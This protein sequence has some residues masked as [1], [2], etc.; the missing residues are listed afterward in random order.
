MFGTHNGSFWQCEWRSIQTSPCNLE[1]ELEF[2]GLLSDPYLQGTMPPEVALL[3]KLEEI[4]IVESGLPGTIETVFPVELAES[5]TNLRLLSFEGN[6]L[7]GTLPTYLSSLTNLQYLKFME[8]AFSGTI[9]S[10]LG[11]LTELIELNLST[12]NIVGTVPTELAG[13][14]KLVS[15][16]ISNTNL[17][18]SIPA[19]VCNLPLLETITCSQMSCCQ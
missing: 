19:E 5:L 4:S 9:P 13:L 16:D 10:E 6:T 18:G 3:T 1:G 12:N 15:L 17:S 2:L 11:L 7:N 8:N 14:T